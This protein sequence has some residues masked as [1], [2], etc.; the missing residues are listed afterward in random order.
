MLLYNCI[1]YLLCFNSQ[2][3]A[4]ELWTLRPVWVIQM[5]SVLKIFLVSVKMENLFAGSMWAW[6]VRLSIHHVNVKYILN[7]ELNLDPPK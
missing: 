7:Y 5:N 4:V 3:T 2:P 6:F 1:K